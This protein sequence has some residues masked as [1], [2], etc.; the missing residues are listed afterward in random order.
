M[1]KVDHRSIGKG[2]IPPSCHMQRALKGSLSLLSSRFVVDAV[3]VFVIV[4]VLVVV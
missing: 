2:G 4:D 1:E 3:V